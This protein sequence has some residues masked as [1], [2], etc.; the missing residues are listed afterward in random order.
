MLGFL[1]DAVCDRL[2]IGLIV[3][4]GVDVRH[5]AGEVLAVHGELGAIKHVE[6]TRLK[7]RLH[8]GN[9]FRGPIRRGAA[10]L[11]QND[12]AGRDR[13]RPVGIDRLAVHDAVDH[14]L[15]VRH[16]V[17]A[18]GDDE[19]FGTVLCRA[20]VVGDVGN[21]CR[22]AGRGRAHGVR[23][24]GNECGAAPDEHIGALALCNFVIPGT[25]IGDFHGDA[26]LRLLLDDGLRA[27]EEGGVAG[28]D[29]RI[30][31]GADIADLDVAVLVV[32]RLELARL[33]HLDQLHARCDACEVSALVNGRECV[34]EVCDPF[35]VRL[36]AGRVAEL[37][38][39]ILARRL[40]DEVLMAEG[41]CKDDVAAL[42][43]EVARSIIAR[44][45]LGNARSDEKLHALVF[46]CFLHRV[47]KVL[48]VG[49]VA[50]MQCNETDGDAALPAVV[51]TLRA[52]CKYAHSRDGKRRCKAKSQQF[53]H[54]FSPLKKFIQ[55]KK[56]ALL[57]RAE[58]DR[59]VG[60]SFNDCERLD[61]HAF[62]AQFVPC[63]LKSLFYGDRAACKPCPRHLDDVHKSPHGVTVR[64]EVVDDQNVVAA[65]DIFVAY[66]NF[67]GLLVG[68]GIHARRI[69]ARGHVGAPVLLGKYHGHMEGDPRRDRYGDA[70]GLDGEDLGHAAAFIEARDLPANL[71]DKVGIDLLIQETSDL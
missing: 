21:A 42:V 19:G 52:S 20:A 2:G 44:L 59:V 1:E 36:R 11:R 29:F 47:D 37:H 26:D 68:E 35:G 56:R 32:V 31:I 3:R 39:G 6:R 28:D 22:L 50:V 7:L 38:V 12:R 16:P 70:R 25:G 48:V 43:D 54:I 17:D 58:F 71:G 9:L 51:A 34:V 13:A 53:F 57:L 69:H 33:V 60:H 63:T 45:I 24:L 65:L 66:G 62:R 4:I 14:V 49:R 40:Q 8:L 15:K 18:R 23:V 67:V 46:A 5:I 55:T 27:E 64:E 30:G 41:I 10:E 61:A